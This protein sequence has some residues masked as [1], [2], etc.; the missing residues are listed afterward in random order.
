MKQKAAISDI[1]TSLLIIALSILFVGW[2]TQ[3]APIIYC[4]FLFISTVLLL[5]A[6]QA[7]KKKDNYSFSMQFL[8]GIGIL[9]VAAFFIFK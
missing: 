5:E 6:I 2:Q 8:R 3:S 1:E 9:I 7:Y 4:S